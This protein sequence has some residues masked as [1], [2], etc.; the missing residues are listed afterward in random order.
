M[1]KRSR[2]RGKFRGPTSR[3]QQSG[4]RQSEQQAEGAQDDSASAAEPEAAAPVAAT[5]G[6]GQPAE[7]V[8]PAQE[9]RQAERRAARRAR[10][11]GRGRGGRGTGGGGGGATLSS[12]TPWIAG[13]AGIIAVIIVLAVV[14]AGGGGSGGAQF[15]DHWH[16]PISI[17]VCG[18]SYT[19][20]QQSP[21]PGLH[22]HNDGVIHIEPRRSGEAGS[23]A[24][25]GTYFRTSQLL[26]EEDLIQIPGEQA[27][28][29]G[30]PCP[31][32]QPG[33]LRVLVNGGEVEDFLNYLPQ[34]GDRIAVT[35]E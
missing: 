19:E 13:G 15:G 14:F 25:L 33:Q 31:D 24:S 27:F 3:R 2:R 20:P 30:D 32:G 22:T 7:P 35:F 17:T 21:L 5:T 29:N 9:P 4:A 28:R 16:A 34:N 18:G 11:R 10:G 12:A 8:R 26:V 23:N 6:G 1:S